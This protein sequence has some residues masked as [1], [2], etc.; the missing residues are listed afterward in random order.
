MNNAGATGN[1]EVLQWFKDNINE[2]LEESWVIG[3]KITDIDI[4]EGYSIEMDIMI[5]LKRILFLMIAYCT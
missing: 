1:I 4:F 5:I 3:C 2:K